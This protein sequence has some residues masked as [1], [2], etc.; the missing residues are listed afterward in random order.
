MFGAHPQTVAPLRIAAQAGAVCGLSPS[1]CVGVEHQV[2][3]CIHAVD[4]VN[5][6]EKLWLG[7]VKFKKKERKNTMLRIK[8]MR[9]VI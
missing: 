4:C 5:M 1:A 3:G 6:S 9:P 7:N 8:I 2:A